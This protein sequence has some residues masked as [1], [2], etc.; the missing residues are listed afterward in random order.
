MGFLKL[1]H[2]MFHMSLITVPISSYY[3]FL[4]SQH[5][6]QATENPFFGI[7]FLRN[8]NQ[9]W[10]K[11]RLNA[12]EQESGRQFQ[13]PQGPEPRDNFKS[14]VQGAP[15]DFCLTTRPPLLAKCLST[16]FQLKSLSGN[17]MGAISVHTYKRSP[18]QLDAIFTQTAVF[19]LVSLW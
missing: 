15:F 4:N 18:A 3:I 13:H 17:T 7:I 6:T 10:E 14:K 9:G 2:I 8:K 19:G 5:F 12:E 11:A 16:S 1:F